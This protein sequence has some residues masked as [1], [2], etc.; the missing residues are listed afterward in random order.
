MSRGYTKYIEYQDGYDCELGGCPGHK[1]RLAYNGSSDT[2]FIEI[3]GEAV[4]WFNDGS[5]HALVQ[6]MNG[7]IEWI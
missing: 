5:L 6:L 3:D 2:A 7:K 1:M 4:H